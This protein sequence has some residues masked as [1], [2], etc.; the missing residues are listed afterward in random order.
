MSRGREDLV[1]T[2]WPDTF[3][4]DDSLT[5][6]LNE[7]RR[8]L[9]DEQRQIVKTVPRRGYIFDGPIEERGFDADVLS[10]RE[11]PRTELFERE[12]P[13]QPKRS[14]PSVLSFPKRCEHN[15]PARL[16]S[17]VGRQ[18]ETSRRYAG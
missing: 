7:I 10:T 17:F 9:E 14:G 1:R 5:K 15:L 11:E 3:V 18:R 2:V 8:A 4:S 13:L 16:T 6:C 12:A